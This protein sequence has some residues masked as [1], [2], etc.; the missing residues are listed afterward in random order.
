IDVSFL[1]VLAIVAGREIAAGKNW[2]NLRVLVLLGLLIAGNVVFHAEVLLKGSADYGVRI[3]IA[4]MLLLISLVGGR[5]V[6]SFT[7]NWIKRENPGRMPVPFLRFDAVTLAASALALTAWIAAPAH[8][9]AGAMLVVAGIL[10]IV[11]LAR[12]AGDRTLAD[13]LVLILHVAYLFVPL[14]FIFVGLSFF[15][16]AVPVSAGLHAWT[17]GAIGLMTLA[18]MTRATLGHTGQPLQASAATQAIY[19]CVLIA[20]V[21]RICAAFHGSMIL[22][23]AAGTL[24]IAGFAG[25]ALVY[26]PLLVR[27][28]P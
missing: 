1:V 15:V 10:Q 20:A 2:R 16:D 11:R 24:W 19:V 12:W 18:V 17:A 3:A 8:P 6:P 25:F 5:I 4:A 28:K 7:G 22:L 9:V 23:E 14:G 21:L 26:A 13:R 27:R